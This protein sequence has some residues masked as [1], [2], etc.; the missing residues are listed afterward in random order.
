MLAPLLS[1][2]NRRQTF[3]HKPNISVTPTSIYSVKW[4]WTIIAVYRH[5]AGRI[6]PWH[7]INSSCWCRRPYFDISWTNCRTKSQ[8][9]PFQKFCEKTSF[10]F[11]FS[12]VLLTNL[13]KFYYV[14]LFLI[15]RLLYLLIRRWYFG[16]LDRFRI[17]LIADYWVRLTII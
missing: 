2:Y 8:L 17:R 7:H 16:G 13:F 3:D 5:S 10:L 9:I 14:A 6:C 1:C 4:R 11:L 15:Q 12:S